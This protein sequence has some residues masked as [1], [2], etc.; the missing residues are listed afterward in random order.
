MDDYL[1]KA[2]RVIALEVDELQRLSDRIATP[3]CEA[4]DALKLAIDQQH[5]IVVVGVGK[6]GNIGHKIAATL[7]STGATA[8]VLNSQNALH[9]DLGLVQAGD[10]V[11]A[12]SQSGETT[13]LLDLLP[14]LCRFDVPI[15]GMTGRMDSS[16]AR[17]SD[18]VLDTSV[19]REACPMN[20][21]PTSSSTVMLVLGDA[22]AM[23]LLEARGFRSEDFARLHPSGHLGRILLTRVSDVMRGEEQLASIQKDATV[24]EA[25]KAMTK[26]RAGAA[27]VV[28]PKGALLGIF[29]HGDFVRAFQNNLA[30][31]DQAVEPFMSS[32]PICIEG[33]RLATEALQLLEKHRVD[34]LI[35]VDAEGMPIGM[36]DTQDL[37][38]MRLI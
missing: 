24:E 18:I 14:N 3:F 6:S 31:R 13:E 26:Q 35:V 11:L 1:D 34:D 37:S 30:I 4:V 9:G 7:N 8:V 5:K 12:M 10:V 16:L 29:T 19:S 17:H 23:V 27:V 38:R 15:I 20:L 36:L 21:A 32:D 22:L 2:K 25:L 28:D 33:Q